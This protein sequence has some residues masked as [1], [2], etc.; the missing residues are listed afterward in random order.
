MCDDDMNTEEN[1]FDG[2][3]CCQPNV[4]CSYCRECQCHNSPDKDMCKEKLIPESC[5]SSSS[6]LM[7]IQGDPSYY[8]FNP[9]ADVPDVIDVENANLKCSIDIDAPPEVDGWWDDVAIG[10]LLSGQPVTCRLERDFGYVN[11]CYKLNQNGT[12]LH[13]HDL[14]VTREDAFG[15]VIGGSYETL[16]VTGGHYWPIDTDKEWFDSTEFVKLDANGNQE[17]DHGPTLPYPVSDHCIVDLGN[18]QMLLNGG[19]DVERSIYTENDLGGWVYYEDH[20]LADTWLYS[21]QDNV[22]TQGP[23]L[24]VQRYQHSCG[25]VK[26]SIDERS[27]IAVV[28]G[29]SAKIKSSPSMIFPLKETELLTVL[30]DSTVGNQWSGGPDLPIV[31][32]DTFQATT[33]DQKQFIIGG[34]LTRDDHETPSFDS[35]F[36][37]RLQ[38]FS[39]K[40]D[41]S[42]MKQEL[43]HDRPKR[44]VAILLPAD[45][46]YGVNCTSTN[47]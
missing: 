3:D 28:V 14:A 29:G 37:F 42:R 21:W 16:W 44:A 27:S 1:E 34:G 23:S 46:D 47:P 19:Y 25:L 22:W 18:G 12:W 30:E 31:L 41:W 43:Q 39:H 26:D 13:F 5:T 38:C 17:N 35:R 9:K 10:G 8:S 24:Y 11:Q 40:C 15:I 7:V 36:L 32:H 45:S 4:D 33:P 20:M 6:R 2:G